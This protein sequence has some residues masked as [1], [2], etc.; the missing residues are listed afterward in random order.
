MKSPGPH[1]QERLYPFQDGV[2]KLVKKLN[3][4]FYLTGGTA[5]SRFYFSHR[6]SDDLDFFVNNRADY[7]LLVNQLFEAFLEAE[8]SGEF[9]V[10]KNAIVKTGHY[11]HLLI[12]THGNITL[13]IELVNDVAVHFGR[14]TLDKKLGRIDSWRNI[15]SNKIAALSRFEPKDIADIWTISLYKKF[16]W[17]DIIGEAKQKDARVE[18][19]NIYEILCSF[20]KI[21]LHQIKWINKIDETAMIKDLHKIATDILEEKPNS[22]SSPSA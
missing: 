15:L 16:R 20:P 17:K 5:L 13:K 4:P 18:P 12:K 19:I 22:L 8:R 3:L 9:I 7:N 10:D 11:T 2:M 6:Y 21:Y 14:V 1:Y